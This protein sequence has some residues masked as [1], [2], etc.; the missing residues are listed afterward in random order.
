M[1]FHPDMCEGCGS[2]YAGLTHTDVVLDQGDVYA[3]PWITTTLPL[4]KWDVEQVEGFRFR[5]K[6]AVD[7]LYETIILV[8]DVTIE[9]C[10]PNCEGKTCGDDGCG[11]TCGFCEDAQVCT[12]FGQCCT[13]DCAGKNCGG[14]G[15]GGSCGLCSGTNS[16]Q[17]G[18]CVGT[19][20]NGV[21]QMNKGEDCE[22]CP[23]DCTSPEE[24][25]LP[26]CPVGKVL[27]CDG[28]CV[29]SLWLGDGYC[30]DMF[31]CAEADWDKG[32]C[33]PCIPSCNDKE[34]GPDGC[35]G[36]CGECPE[37]YVCQD[38]GVCEK[39]ESQ[40]Q[41]KECGDD[42]CGGLCGVC[43]DKFVCGVN[44]M[45]GE[46]GCTMTPSPGCEDCPC[47]ECVC[48][49]DPFCCGVLWDALCVSTCISSCGGCALSP[50]EPSDDS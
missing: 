39:C 28:A 5:S 32:D 4:G 23:E 33:E 9:E 40:C 18:Q 3:T 31:K 37:D 7:F 15:C 10:T 47:E 24:C 20:G 1:C 11:G 2:H 43:A 36:L 6:S 27:N 12:K 8:D 41:D 50:S 26:E 49:N 45:C 42:G 13:P 48:E 29:L 16:C 46:A 25:P 30:D 35:G 22:N 14:D 21:C 19:C 34:C 17:S 44:G 38:Y